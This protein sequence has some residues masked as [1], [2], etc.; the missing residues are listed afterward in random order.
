MA[1][2]GVLVEREAEGYAAY[3]PVISDAYGTGPTPA[4]AMQS[5]AD[6]IQ[7]LLPDEPD[8]IAELLEERELLS[9]Q[10]HMLEITEGGRRPRVR[11]QKLGSLTDIADRLRVT[12]QTVWNWTQRYQDFPTPLAQTSAGPYWALPEV[13]RWAKAR[14]RKAG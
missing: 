6:L 5:L 10:A 8:G 7:E 12:R 1:T 4:A 11:T 13:E 2:F 14:K 9:V 3:A